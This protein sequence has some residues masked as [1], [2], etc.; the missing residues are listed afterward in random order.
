MPRRIGYFVIGAL[1]SLTAG[2]SNGL[3]T[4]NLTQIQGALGLTSVE[5]EWLSAAYSMSNV[6]TSFLLIKFRQQFGLQRIARP[7]LLGF[8]LLSGAQVLVHS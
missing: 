5:T 6:C 2:L 1:V 4:A 8:V 7:F 3:L